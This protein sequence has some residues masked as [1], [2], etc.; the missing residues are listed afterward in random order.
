MQIP[1]QFELG[2]RTWEVRLPRRISGGLYGLVHP[3]LTTIYVATGKRTPRKQ[4]E[5]F[6]HEVTHAILHDMGDPRWADEKFVEGFSKRLN[7]VIHTAR[8]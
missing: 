4:A 1:K 3:L 8:F 5:S 6:W 2:R 7:N